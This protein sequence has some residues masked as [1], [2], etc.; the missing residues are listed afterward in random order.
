MESS[1]DDLAKEIERALI[2]D[3]SGDDQSERGSSDKCRDRNQQNHV[4]RA[5]AN[6]S[7]NASADANAST[8]ANVKANADADARAAASN[9][10]KPESS[11]QDSSQK[12]KYKEGDVDSDVDQYVPEIYSSSEDSDDGYDD[13]AAYR[14]PS[15]P[16]VVHAPLLAPGVKSVFPENLSVLDAIVHR[17]KTGAAKKIVVMAGAGISTDAGIPDF[18]SPGT[19][20]YDNLQTYK[21]PYPE[22]IF[23]IDYFRKKP[24]PFYVL[25]KE[26]YP[27]QFTPTQSHFFVKLL[28]EKG[29]LQRHY[30]QNI[31]C[32]ER[33]AGI[34]PDLIVEA[35]G[36]FHTAHCISRMC[37]QEH[38]Q[39]WVK[40]KI[41]ADD[42]PR[43]LSCDSLVKPDI[44]FFGEGLP[45]RFFDLL[46]QD[47]ASC[48]LLI[49]MGTS[50]LV[51]PFASLINDVSHAVPRLLINRM[52]VGEAKTPGPGFD[53]D[54]RHAGQLHRDALVLGDCDQA[55]ALLAER[56]GWN[57]EL[58]VLRDQFL[59]KPSS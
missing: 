17:I 1:V 6:A 3:Q 10:A 42:I 40:E 55:C 15:L 2:I 20:L 24:K 48:D 14:G 49:V 39:S 59:A 11:G 26:L 56:L 22:A 37:R 36:S 29:L 23:S 54:G 41:F 19:G 32:L 35:H 38:S 27:G 28:A 5:N 13:S 57:K 8:D 9:D 34:D 52:R 46:E 44:T 33:V 50:L 25:A 30:T 47:F 43:C 58:S 18:R 31:D 21:L 16:L 53:F 45:S 51:Q 12:Q 4:S 7:G